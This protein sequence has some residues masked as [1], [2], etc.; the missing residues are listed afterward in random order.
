MTYLL[1]VWILNLGVEP[2]LRSA[3]FLLAPIFFFLFALLVSVCLVRETINPLP[4]I[5][6]QL[7]KVGF[8]CLVNIKDI[9]VPKCTQLVK[10]LSLSLLLF[11]TN[12]VLSSENQATLILTIGELREIPLPA[13]A[14]Y[15]IGNPDTVSHKY[16]ASKE[17]LLLKGKKLG[18]S[19][20]RYWER[21]KQQTTRLKVYVIERRKQLQ[22]LQTLS[23]IESIGLK[24]EMLGDFLK[25]S[26]NIETIEAYR[27]FHLMRA[28]MGESLLLSG[29][30]GRELRLKLIGEAYSLFYAASVKGFRCYTQNYDFLCRVPSKAN[31]A[32]GLMAELEKSTVV[33]IIET[34]HNQVDQN[35]TLKIKLLQLE[36][37][38]GRELSFGLDKLSANLAEVFDRGVRSLI[39]KNQILINDFDLDVST[40]AEPTGLI[41]LGHEAEFKI[42]AEIPYQSEVNADTGI[43]TRQWKFVGL[44]I[45]VKLQREA[46][47]Y[48]IYY[49]TEFSSPSQIEGEISGNYESSTAVIKLG[50]PT[51]LFQIGLKT[52]GQGQSKLPL[53]SQI[54]LLGSLFTSKTNS[55]T[56][57]KISGLILLEQHENTTSR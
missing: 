17:T 21:G 9:L 31:L 47:H 7:Q 14:S 29:E 36:S 3:A 42:G 12:Q 55:A 16:L 10:I 5:K 11:S 2:L 32:P 34:D 37:L 56:H 25:I 41:R 54:P 13:S 8:I 49:K 44:K 6:Y 50:S 52:V 40:L 38:N 27:Q 28:E 51:E 18:F 19:E 20:V 22:A 39:D 33:K 45:N 35:F 48:I 23:A 4:G 24:V 1:S 26:G 46:G 30:L 57:K 43:S 53:L 15:S